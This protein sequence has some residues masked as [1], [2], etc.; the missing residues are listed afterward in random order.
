[1]TD[2]IS[3]ANAGN[4]SLDTVYLVDDSDKNVILEVIIAASGQAAISSV[5]LDSLTIYKNY[6]GTYSERPLGSNKFLH[7]KTLKIVAFITDLAKET[8][9]MEMNLRLRGGLGLR[10]YALTK[11][12]GEGAGNLFYIALIEFFKV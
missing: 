5:M 10:Q 8:N 12:F 11:K 3:I 2:T 6:P 9:I 4:A 7:G 1:M